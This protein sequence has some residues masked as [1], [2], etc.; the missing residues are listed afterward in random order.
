MVPEQRPLDDLIAIFNVFCK[1]LSQATFGRQAALPS[2]K[3]YI[4]KNIILQVC[5]VVGVQTFRLD[6]VEAR[7]SD[8]V[9]TFKSH[10]E[11]TPSP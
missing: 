8:L 6:L 11:E 2:S 7:K 5:T 10:Q 3:N 1:L 4:I 9:I